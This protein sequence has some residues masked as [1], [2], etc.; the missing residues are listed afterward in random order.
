LEIEVQLFPCV[1][2]DARRGIPLKKL[3]VDDL[4]RLAPVSPERDGRDLLRRPSGLLPASFFFPV[5]A[6]TFAQ[7]SHFFLHE[8]LS[9]IVVFS[10]MAGSGIIV[11]YPI[12]LSGR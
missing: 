12:T 3:P 5:V 6:L 4:C 9:A 2:F 8:W 7:D 10:I 1:F 11:S